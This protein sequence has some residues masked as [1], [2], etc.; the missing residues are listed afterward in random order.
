MNMKKIL[1]LLFLSLFFLMLPCF[2]I[3]LDGD[4]ARYARYDNSFDSYDVPSLTWYDITFVYLILFVIIWCIVYNFRRKTEKTKM[5]T[6]LESQRKSSDVYDSK[7]EEEQKKQQDPLQSKK[8][9]VKD[10]FAKYYPKIK[11]FGLSPTKKF[12]ILAYII[13]D[14]NLL[15]NLLLKGADIEVQDFNG[16]NVLMLAAKDGNAEIVK[17]LLQYNANPNILDHR[18]Y[19]ALVKTI[20]G[21]RV[22]KGK[23]TLLNRIE[24]IRLL[25]SAGADINKKYYDPKS[26]QSPYN[27]F[28]P[29]M[30]AVEKGNVKLIKELIKVGANVNTSDSKGRTPFLNA[31][32]KNIESIWSI[33]LNNG[34]DPNKMSSLK[35]TPLTFACRS[36]N[37]YLVK[38]LLNA[39]IDLNNKQAYT[40]FTSAVSQGD[41]EI[42]KLLLDAGIK[43]NN[44]QD[45]IEACKQNNEEI[46]QF[47][48]QKNSSNI[49]YQNEEGKTALMIA[50]ETGNPTLVSLLLNAGADPNIKDKNDEAPLINWGCT[51]TEIIRLLLSAG[52]DI[53]IMNKDRNTALMNS[54]YFGNYEAA[55]LLIQHGS[56]LN[57]KNNQGLSPLMIAGQHGHI[58]MV[59]LLILSGADYKETDIDNQDVLVL[60]SRYGHIEVVKFLLKMKEKLNLDTSLLKAATNGY[61]DIVK[62]LISAGANVNSITKFGRTPLMLAA[63]NGHTETVNVLLEAEAKIN[64]ADF[65]RQTALMWASRN[66]HIQVTHLLL[67]KGANVNIQSMK[68][69]K[70]AL[71]EACKNGHLEIVRMLLNAGAKPNLSDSNKRTPLMFAYKNLQEGIIQLLMDSGANP[72][73]KDAFGNTACFYSNL[74]DFKPHKKTS[75][76]HIDSMD[77]YKK[78]W[79]LLNKKN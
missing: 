75:R 68:E 71:I 50:C 46:L 59:K 73:D 49:N 6:E 74:A 19:S 53:H 55:K 35:E 48:L 33:L 70:T 69:N 15:R 14:F 1:S 56:E 44:R 22:V 21:F 60:A 16:E 5:F 25:V 66:G 38:L 27:G 37:L 63:F 4:I 18:G 29:L 26:T 41:T 9:E 8:E 57:T 72:N 17:L 62:I 23:D 51:N 79:A 34:A 43:P 77:P 40:A 31:N 42:V 64:L 36:G 12:I 39:G 7:K 10:E 76:E 24:I 65:N 20:L 11:S 67:E 78:I 28:S 61:Q 3:A 13:E 54:C 2:L 45:L 30:F 47:L 58:D 52:A 32:N